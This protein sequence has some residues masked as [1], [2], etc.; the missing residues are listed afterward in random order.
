MIWKQQCN[1]GA[2]LLLTAPEHPFPTEMAPLTWPYGEAFDTN[3]TAPSGAHSKK[4][5]FHWRLQDTNLAC[6]EPLAD[7]SD[8][9]NLLVTLLVESGI[10]VIIEINRLEY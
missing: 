5:H 6:H 4:L 8:Q 7:C 10:L 9:G 1:A 2:W 3:T